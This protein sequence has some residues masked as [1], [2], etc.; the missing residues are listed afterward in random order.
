MFIIENLDMTI[1]KDVILVSEYKK[2]LW[3]EFIKL[4]QKCQESSTKA[5]S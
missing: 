4:C 3:F 2:I 5:P 1:A